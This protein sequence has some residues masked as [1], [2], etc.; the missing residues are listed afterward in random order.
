[1]PSRTGRRGTLVVE[2]IESRA[3][4]GNA[5]GDPSERE[6]YVY[7]PPG[8][9]PTGK[10][11]YPVVVVIV[12]FTGIAEHPW[13]RSFFGEG[14]HERMDRLIRT[15]KCPPMILA[16]PDCHT[17]L[18]GSQYV[19]SS[20]T[21]N[22]ETFTAKEVPRH[23]DAHFRT[24]PTARHRAICGKS[25]GGIGS[26][27]L[28]MRHPDVFGALACHSGDAY[29]E[30]CYRYS[31]VD[32]W[33]VLRDA[34]GVARWLKRFERNKGRIKPN[35][36]SALNLL[37]MCSCYLPN[38]ESPWGFD[39]PFDMETGAEIPAVMRRWRKFDPVY[40]CKR[41]AN[42]LRKLRGIFIDCGIRDEWTLAVGARVL[43]QRLRQLGIEH[44]H[45]EF[46]GTH[47]NIAYRYDVSLPLLGK[48]IG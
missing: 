16:T 31:F 22:Y 40:A 41:Y 42:N 43:S 30:Y 26:L 23:L 15:R 19:N 9:S 5:M 2:R 11:T 24:K 29:F 48:W 28:G 37:G 12:G 6:L 8:Y 46:D 20:A 44:V 38:P 34:G 3:L 7:L 35:E 14:L 36:F 4:A 13:Q 47:R 25:S 39:I 10:R 33:N 17:S 32:A 21:G 45:E 27:W 18:G 1:M